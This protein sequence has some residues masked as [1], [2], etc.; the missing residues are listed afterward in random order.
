VFDPNRS[1]NMPGYGASGVTTRG[2]NLL[3]AVL[4]WLAASLVLTGVGVYAAFALGLTLPWFLALILLIGLIFAINWAARSNNQPLAVGLFFVFSIAEGMFLAPVIAYYLRWNPAAIGNAILG[5]AGVFVVAAS[6]VY[7]SNRSFASWGKYLLMALIVG[8]VLAIASIF[9][10]ISQ[11]A[12]SGFLGI[13]FVGLTIF[14]FWRV[15]A[16]RPGDDNALL[17]AVSLYL[18]FV[19]IFLILLQI[20]GGGNNRR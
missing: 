12:I 10:P 3:D 11:L 4:G 16:A 2:T 8:I 18:D 9:L 7:I 17:I 13:V 6:V 15:K 1:A 14:D 20:F 5:T 19:N